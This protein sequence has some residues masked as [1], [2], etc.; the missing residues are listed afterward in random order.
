[1]YK[2]NNTLTSAYGDMDLAKWQGPDMPHYTVSNRRITNVPVGGSGDYIQGIRKNTDLGIEDFS[3]GTPAS[4]DYDMAPVRPLRYTPGLKCDAHLESLRPSRDPRNQP[5]QGGDQW[6]KKL[7]QAPQT[8]DGSFADA[9]MQKFRP[10]PNPNPME[11]PWYTSRL[12]DPT[13]CAVDRLAMPF[14]YGAVPYGPEVG[15][16]NTWYP[17]DELSA[18]KMR[19]RRYQNAVMGEMMSLN[20][21]LPGGYYPYP[22][23]GTMMRGMPMNVP[24]GPAPPPPQM[25]DYEQAADE[26]AILDQELNVTRRTTKPFV[27]TNSPNYWGL[28]RQVQD[29]E[30]PIPQEKAPREITSID[31]LPAPKRV[32]RAPATEAAM[33]KSNRPEVRIAD[34]IAIRSFVLGHK[35]PKIG[36][37]KTADSSA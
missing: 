8:Y 19:N 14:N 32:V 21:N 11:D 37:G 23:Q 7:I 12:P 34:Q 4:A 2:V 22:Q 36:S 3:K 28:Q 30:Q 10:N 13:M 27:P 25:F 24:M 29:M 6:K 26:L 31:Q 15:P 18:I 35:L 33:P 5:I 16:Y 1:M 9:D 17:Q 20:G